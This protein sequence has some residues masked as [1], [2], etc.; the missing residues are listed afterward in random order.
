MTSSIFN[1]AID[2]YLSKFLEINRDETKISLW[3]GEVEMSN[4]KIKSEIFTTMNLPYFELVNGYIGKI[5][6]NVSL[7]RFYL[8]PIKVVVEKVFFHAKQ[9]KLETINKKTEIDNMETYKNNKLLSMEELSNEVN[10]LKTEGGAGYLD[11]I[12]NNLEIEIKDICVRFDDDLSYNLIPFTFGLLLKNLKISTVDENFMEAKEGQTI[13]IGEVNRKLLKMTNFSIYFDTYENEKKLVD[14]NSRIVDKEETEVKDEKFKKFLGPMLN[15]YRYCLSETEVYINDRKAHQYLNFDSGFVIK[16]SMNTNLKNG[17]PQYEVECQLNKILMSMSLVQIKAAMKLLAYQDL[18][19]KYQLG[20]AK[21]YYIKVLKEND[22]TTYID[23]YIEYYKAKYGVKK[24]EKQAK[25]LEPVL[26]QIESGL[27]YD[28]IQLMREAAKYKIFHDSEVDKIDE[29]IKKLQGGGGFFGFFSSG[30]NEEQ[31][32]EIQALNEQKKKLLKKNVNEGMKELLNKESSDEIDTM[33]DIPDNFCLYRVILNL[34]NFSLDINKLTNER[35]LSIESNNFDLRA[36]IRKKGQFFSLLIDDISVK[37]YQLKNKN[38]YDTLIATIDQKDDEKKKSGQSRKGACYIEFEN[39]PSFEKS[40][41]R[42]LFRNKKRLIITVNL[43]SI[44][45]IMNKVLESLAATISKFGSERYIGSGE[46]QNLIKSGFEANYITGGFQHF[47]IDLDIEMKSPYI[48]FPQNIL[49]PY[50]K[51]CMFIRC[52][53]FIMKS[54]LPPRQVLGKNYEL[55]NVREELFDI[56]KMKIENFSMFTVDEFR[57][58]FNNLVNLKGLDIVEN[59][60]VDFQMDINFEQKNKNFEKIKMALNLGKFRF[61]L[62]DTQIIFFIE[63]LE[64]MQQMNKQVSFDVEKKT[65][66]FEIE[67]ER[68][69]KE[70]L[71]KE[72]K[73]KKEKKEEKDEKEKKEQKEKEK[74]LNELKKKEDKEKK[75]EEIQGRLKPDEDPKYLIFE[76]NIESIELSLMKSISLKERDILSELDPKTIQ[77]IDQEYRDFIVFSLN[78]FNIGFITT[79]KGNMEVD[80]SMESTSIKDMET[81]IISKENPKGDILINKE[82]QYLIHMRAEEPLRPFRDYKRFLKKSSDYYGIEIVKNEKKKEENNKKF[83]TIEYR[84]NGVNKTQEVNIILE[85][86]RICFSMSS[87]VRLYQFYNYYFGMYSKSC[88]NVTYILANMEEKNKR[89]NLKN[90]VDVEKKHTAELKFES[91]LSDISDTSDYSTDDSN[92]DDTLI[93]KYLEE[94]KEKKKLFGDKFAKTLEQQ[95]NKN[96]I[97]TSTN[98]IV[99]KKN[100]EIIEDK[101]ETKTVREKSNMKINFVMKE[102]RLDFPLDDTQNKTKVLRFN[103]NFICTI[104]MN[105][106]YDSIQNALGRQIRVNYITNNMKLSAKCMKVG[107]EIAH[108]KNGEYSINNI[109]DKM[110]QGFRFSTNINS[111]LLLPQKEKSVMAINVIFEPLIFNIGFRQTKTLMTFL[112][113]LTQFLTD[114]YKDYDDP[115]KEL[116]DIDN[117]PKNEIIIEEEN[118]INNENQIILDENENEENLTEEELKQRELKRKRKIERYNIKQKQ[119]LAAKKLKEQKEKELEEGNQKQIKVI[120]NTDGLNNMIDVK[121]TFEKFSFKYL[122]DSGSY[123][124]PLLS[125]ENHDILVHYIQNSRPDSVENISNLIL[126]SVARTEVKLEDYDINGLFMFVEINFDTSINFYNDRV[127]N[128]EPIIERYRGALKVD[129]ATSFSRM[130]VLFKSEDMFNINVSI[131][132]MNVLNRVLKKFGESEEKWDKELKESDELSKNTNSRAAVE[133]MNLSGVDIICWVDAKDSDDRKKGKDKNKDK[134]N[135]MNKFI[136]TGSGEKSKKTIMNGQLSMYYQQLSEAKAKIKKNKFS[137]QIRGYVPIYDNDFSTNYTSSFRMKKDK[138]AKNEIRPIYLQM[139]NKKN[140][141]NQSVQSNQTNQTDDTMKRTNSLALSELLDDDEQSLISEASEDII[142][143]SNNKN[144][145]EGMT[146]KLIELEKQIPNLME[147]ELEI[148]VKV[149]QSGTMKSIVFESNIFIFNNLQIPIYLSFISPEDYINKYGGNDSNINH[150]ENK[151]KYILNTCK[152]LSIPIN[153]IVNKYR[154]Y[155]SFY[156]KLNEKDNNFVLLY[157]N[158]T[159]IKKNLP[160]FIKF[161]KENSPGYEGE[162]KTILEDKYS[163]MV[164][165]N[166]NNQRFYI[167]CNLLIQKGGGDTISD[168]PNVL[169]KVSGYINAD[170]NDKSLRTKNIESLIGSLLNDYYCKTFSYLFI[171]DESLLIENKIPFNIKCKLSGAKE[172]EMTIRPLQQKEFLEMDQSKTSLQISLNYQNKQFISDILNIRELDKKNIENNK[173]YID[174]TNQIKLYLEDNKDQFIE[175]EIAMQDNFNP[176]NLIG[177]YEKEYEHSLR[178]FQN[179]KKLVIYTKC[180]F[181]NKTENLLYLLSEDDK[182]L[183]KESINKI[184]NYNYK[185]LPNSINLLNAKDIKKPFKLRMENTD[186]SKKFNINTVGNTGVTSLFIPDKTNKDKITILDVGISIPTSYYFTESLLITIVPRYM[187]INKLG[188]DL[189]YK[190]YN[191]K[192]SKEKNDNSE[193]FEKNL[194]KN[195]DIVNLNLLK[196]NKNMKKMLQI[197]FE[198]SKDFSAPFDLEEMCD[199]DLKIE[200]DEKMKK[201]IEKE[202]NKIDKEIKKLKKLEEKKK[203]EELM[204]D[205]EKK[206]EIIKN[207]ENEIEENKDIISDDEDEDE[208]EEIIPK[209]KEKKN[210]EEKEE[211]LIDEEKD[212]DK[213]EKKEELSPE[214]ERQKRLEEKNKLLEK[215]KMKPRKYIIFQQNKRDYIL[216]H[217]SKSTENGLINIVVYPPEYPQYK[218]SNQSKY[219]LTFKQ[220][221]DDY[222]K[223]QFYLEHSTYEEDLNTIPYVWADPLKNDK[224]LIVMLDKNEIEL[225]LNEIKITKKKFEVKEGSKNTSYTF[226][227]Q[228]LIE[229]NKTRKLVIKNETVKNINTGYFLEAMKGQKKSANIK[230]KIDTKGLG[231]SIINNEPK[232]IFYISSYGCIIKGNQ[233]TFKKD[234]CD[235]AIINVMF[236]LK[237]FQIDYCLEDNFKS[238][239]IPVNP[240]TPTTEAEAA[241]NKQELYPLIDSI[242]SFHSTTNPLTQI[243]SDEIPQIDLVIQPF[244]LNISQFQVISLLALYQEILPEL[245]FFIVTPE[246]HREYNNIEELIQSLFGEA[247]A[248]KDELI[249]DPQYYDKNLDV[250]LNTMPEQIIHEA[251]NH[252]IFF[253]KNIHIGAL[254]MIITTRIDI[255][256]FE[257]ILP[258]YLLGVISALGN[259]ILHI[260]DYKLKFATSLYSDVFTDVFSLSNTL[261]NTYYRQLI[262]GLFKIVGSLDILGNP[263]GYASSIAD[264]FMQIIEAPRKGLINGPLGF[265]E[266]IAKGFGSFVSTVLSSSFD[267]VGKISGTLLASCEMLQGEKVFEELEEREPEHLLDGLY[268]GLKEGVKDLGKGLGGIFYKPYQGAKKEGVKGFFKGLGSGVLGAVVSPF[269]ALFRVTNNVF[270][271]LKNTVNMFNP[272]LKTDRFRYPRT[273]EKAEGLKSY[274]EDK[275]TIKAILDFLKEYEGQEIVFFRQFKYFAPGLNNNSDSYLILTSKCVIVVYE[276]KEVVFKLLVDEIK[277]VEVHREEN[278][279]NF[280]IIFNLIDNSRE[281]IKTKEVNVC[282]DFYLMFESSKK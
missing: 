156:N 221:K 21:E 116:N 250:S 8:Y 97:S 257:D 276:A 33:K 173:D 95:F 130:R 82:F 119:L 26:R 186:W 13:P 104:V 114:M 3:N 112:P 217:I 205:K 196:A 11:N 122:D 167:S 129:Q 266:G 56:Y 7:P 245:N 154:V 128:W 103:F 120:S 280:D 136:L 84:S 282:T 105:S 123:L 14:F 146:E 144:G 261:Y 24:N 72:E 131:S 238:M 4:V 73:E 50:N 215:Y 249:Y 204:K 127:N 265:G 212:E 55:S 192:I 233:F 46:I 132:S 242:I 255:S 107:F 92:K 273:I 236:T 106:E 138:I 259:V 81:L 262:F 19:S 16:L 22:K 54:E 176:T 52:G 36:E 268:M 181:V 187:F 183:E 240:M 247:Q 32:K 246:P 252:W 15:Y 110:L 169:E 177:A 94:N 145:Q 197:K 264:G 87:M 25:I 239:F 29:K 232:E 188:F 206:E 270:V 153:F 150:A 74:Q 198:N 62:R 269:T 191:N 190:Q 48:I 23:S 28:E 102:T 175:C 133:F 9:K 67:E 117:E 277:S 39:N 5:K 256:A 272:K 57:G 64:K 182:N 49:D 93:K 121:V 228:T 237:N 258:S 194:I 10:N 70:D 171:L 235:H 111:F 219:R 216:V 178:S 77:N 224:T 27:K 193:L 174:Q 248:Q 34:P 160:E 199:T 271:G 115:L 134:K 44:Q 151:D 158:F 140:Q 60:T 20:L 211:I 243:S 200:I 189:E 244:K 68:Q 201:I 125:I 203:K 1:W 135:V 42:F 253:I 85:K 18:N 137:F 17:R 267:V 254:E 100:E 91:K 78:K 220:K 225:N 98:E 180:I 155:V 234:D 12:I 195:N 207:I 71:A 147:D 275:A 179:K 108:F 79:E 30:P 65:S 149:R 229:K 161:N 109:C 89:E 143:T 251:E 163:K 218:I 99:L 47:N 172:K 80:I 51:K 209:K 2:K 90:K 141:A 223:E 83:M 185:I 66:L 139:K 58:D 113:K 53:D 69:N 101:G 214:E 168:M 162:K 274:D 96:E 202:N 230:F 166:Q 260:T 37:Q 43:Y 76:F 281:Y 142:S 227:F 59:I 63:L 152:K 241:K 165:I 159:N 184:D 75:K 124:I 231:I 148:L 31:K 35:M 86:I 222:N 126:E 213:K 164:E 278:R 208:E 38:M 88:E 279:T 45:Y 40:N 157:E 210:E 41:F 263:T 226:Y 170:P 6:L 61:D 118:N